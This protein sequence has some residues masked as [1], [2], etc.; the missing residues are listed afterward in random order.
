MSDASSYPA[1]GLQVDFDDF[2]H[3]DTQI[4]KS[5]EAYGR[6]YTAAEKASKTNLSAAAERSQRVA[7]QAADAQVM[8]VNRILAAQRGLAGY[9]AQQAQ[10]AQREQ[11]AIA[12]QQEQGVR[13]EA[14]ARAKSTSDFR[15]MMDERIA[16]GRAAA[17]SEEQLANQTFQTRRRL[18]VQQAALAEQE[19]R[20]QQSAN[21]KQLADF[22]A[23]MDG[24]IALGR[25]AAKEAEATERSTFELR[26]RL[27]AQRS[28]EE[29]D[30]DRDR[31]RAAKE[32]AEY[33]ARAE[34]VRRRQGAGGVVQ[35]ADVSLLDQAR[36]AM[37]RFSAATEGIRNAL[38][39]LRVA[40][41][42]LRTV[43]AL[44]LGGLIVGPMVRFAD[45]MTA[46]EA[47]IGFFAKSAADVPYLFE[48]VFETAQ[49][50]R[51]PLEAVATLYTRLAPLAD[52]LGRSQLQLL[53]VT[54]T[55]QKGIAIGGATGAEATSS[56]QQLAQALA[57]NRLG[58][59]ELRSL[60]E[61]A[62]VLLGAIARELNMSTGEFIKW[63]HAGKANTEVV[64]SALERAAPRIDALFADFPVTISQGV[65][66][67]RNSIQK[68]VGEVNSATK[69]GQQIG[70]AF[71][72]FSV[73]ISSAETINAVT[74]AVNALMLSFKAI[75][76]VVGVVVDSLP[77]II[78]LLGVLAVRAVL[79]SAAV[80]GIGVAFATTAVMLGPSATAITVATTTMS[81]AITRLGVVAKGA[82]AFVGGPF[83][84][85]LLVAA[86]AFA[87]FQ[88]NAQSAQEATN[89]FDTAQQG[90]AS[91]MDR[92]LTI[93]QTYGA[94]TKEMTQLLLELNGVQE[95]QV[96]GL[97]DAG[98]AAVARAENERTLTVA[99]LRRAAAD[100]TAAAAAMDRGALMSR[101]QR[102]SLEL[103]PMTGKW[104][105]A[106]I[107]QKMTGRPNADVARADE[108]IADLRKAEGFQS[109]LAAELR[110]SA[111]K[112]A[113]AADILEKAK[114]KVTTPDLSGD[115][116]S[117][118]AA[119][120]EKRDRSLDSATNRVAKLAA[121]VEGLRNQIGAL[122]VD[123]LSDIS[124]RI[125]A[126]GAEEAA[127]Y[128]AG[129]AADAGFAARAKTLAMQ[130]EELQIRLEM[131]RTLIEQ[132]R[133]TENEAAALDLESRGRAD[134]ERIM[135]SFFRSGTRGYQAYTAAVNAAQRA[136]LEGKIA[137][138]DL[139][140]AQ[141]FGVT[142]LNDISRALQVNAGMSKENADKL[143][144]QAIAT[145]AAEA[146][147]KR[148]TLATDQATDAEKAYTDALD[149][150]AKVIAALEDLERDATLTPQQRDVAGRTAVLQDVLLKQ[151]QKDNVALT[152]EQARAEAEVLAILERQREIRAQMKIDIQDSIRQA[153]IDSGR[154]DFSSLRK[155]L[156]REFR[157]AIYDALIAKAITPVVNVIVK[158]VTEGI[159]RL[160][161]QFKDLLAKMK[162]GAD[163]GGI[164]GIMGKMLKG[165]DG[166][167]DKVV[168]KGTSGK[169]VGG[170]LGN[171]VAGY[172][173]GS[174]AAEMVGWTGATHKPGQQLAMDAIFAT[175][176]TAV[177]GPIGASIATF[178]S[179][180]LGKAILGKES[181]YGAIATFNDAGGYSL[182]GNKRNQQTSEMATAAAEAV[183]AG[184]KALSD[185][186]IQLTGS[187][188]SIDIGT[189][190]AA[191]IILSN[192]Q[193]LSS[194]VGDA[195]A[196]AE[197]ALKALLQGATYTSDA[198]KQ[199]VD[200][201]IAAGKG[202]DDIIAKLKEYAEAQKFFTSVG[203]EILRY[204]NPKEFEI[205][206]LRDAQKERRD[207]AEAYRAQGLLTPEQFATLAAQLTQLDQLEMADL[208]KRLV[209]VLTDAQKEANDNVDKARADLQAAYERERDAIQANIDKFTRLA[210]SLKAFR[211]S[212]TTGP[213][214]SN[215]LA[216]QYALTRQSFFD[217]AALASA[218]DA[219][220]MGKLPELGK[221][222][223][224]ASKAYSVTLVDYQRDLAQVRNAV[225]DAEK[226]AQAQVSLGEQQ[227]AALN[228]QV[229]GLITVNESVLSV[230]QAIINL[231]AALAAQTAA[232][233]AA[234]TPTPNT[235]QQP[236]AN[237][238]GTPQTQSPQTT[239]TQDWAA[240]IANNSDVA[241]EYARNM[242][243]EKG[244]QA[245]ANIGVGSAQDFGQWHWNQFGQYEPG[246][247]V[248]TME[249]PLTREAGSSAMATA[250]DNTSTD[251]M[252]TLIE[253]VDDLVTG[254]EQVVVNTGGSLRLSK[255]WDGDG[256]PET[257][258]VLP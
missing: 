233:L 176:G 95:T 123:P 126:A 216:Q 101:L 239:T 213:L 135:Q 90:A 44:F 240:Y 166:W 85:A 11:Q 180:G 82:L 121:E 179:R 205:A 237:D 207:Q 40:F 160:I 164:M 71:A 60:A 104:G 17:R 181:N 162:G 55:V 91:A 215:T 1:V 140:V 155:A 125:A 21:A 221:N 94:D 16:A 168:P 28:K 98:K 167:L 183:L 171:A 224:D 74:Q 65:T 254:I 88:A 2:S 228:A 129:K 245:L 250:N 56:A 79:A 12:R 198:Q 247:S 244:R 32:Q 77:V 107:N 252:N 229:A 204:T 227:L 99:L 201:M 154:L 9:Q 110:A 18:T 48:A 232:N 191:T 45:Q 234:Q 249:V 117:S 36:A 46:L 50:T 22:R 200:S 134:A 111:P 13:A 230:T 182:S 34:A 42:D 102:L 14:A 145:A 194:A 49:R 139:R 241:A 35:P 72:D 223:L 219:D 141:T 84:A 189:R 119:A 133:A 128:T 112:T 174:T 51:A 202:F 6:L 255:R 184:T 67:V 105:G 209:D 218:G 193:K 242:A 33:L 148:K 37:G 226:S 89:R 138:D 257:R 158:V 87:V 169:G 92:G 210:E 83:G 86:G 41:F 143:Q 144:A 163:Q 69:A 156:T 258:S 39:R 190:D 68:L 187:V 93:M 75:G 243:S 217:T 236:G 173:I 19:L 76:T 59:D 8:S 47:R 170:F 103:D 63:A 192:G 248:P 10:A 214:A 137:A 23:M 5:I 62:P 222:F 27:N 130:K 109:A 57:S 25:A 53:K 199:L 256:M 136:E 238:N 100:Q 159:D 64:I 115:G 81:A 122:T 80:K 220:A 7:Q 4:D 106:R 26:R 211:E 52:Q 212:L 78:T 185:A 132:Q 150:Q 195:G 114:L 146:A 58:G 186:G 188:K 149:R 231:Q 3:L 29:A 31:L 178:I 131:T 97:D 30:A 251:Q 177:G 120:A 70:S 66:L 147:T 165:L 20:A 203:R 196:A 54:E 73:F 253:R 206:N 142:S 153:F 235:P 96:E 197:T 24:R 157:R 61:N 246:R 208:Q 124:A 175:I 118:S 172:Q 38:H 161:A 116:N 43:V 108:Q 113:R 152:D 225:E 15:K 151:A 127:K